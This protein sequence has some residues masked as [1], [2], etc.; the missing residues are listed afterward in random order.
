MLA[1]ALAGSLGA[2]M[3]ASDTGALGVAL[4]LAGCPARL[5]R[6]AASEASALASRGAAEVLG[7]T[8]RLNGY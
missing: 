3:A 5:D 1:V 7:W 4:A 8:F 6:S 2:A